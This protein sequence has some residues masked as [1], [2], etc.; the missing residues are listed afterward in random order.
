M[1][2]PRRA[3]N[4]SHPTLSATQV[5]TTALPTTKAPTLAPTFDCPDEAPPQLERAQF[6]DTGARLVVAF[7]AATDFGGRRAGEAFGCSELLDF[8]GASGADCVWVSSAEVHATV[9]GA[10]T[11]ALVEPDDAV[12][13]FGGLVRRSC[14]DKSLA[15]RIPRRASR[16]GQL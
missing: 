9:D 1:C 7:D 3:S 12:L 2:L 16:R 6:D 10:S 14:V 11:E 5:P 8:P 13:V 4:G 15:V